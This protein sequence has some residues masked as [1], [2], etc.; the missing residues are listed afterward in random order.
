MLI[1]N[2]FHCGGRAVLKWQVSKAEF[3]LD[4]LRVNITIFFFFLRELHLCED[5]SFAN[6]IDV[7]YIETMVIWFAAESTV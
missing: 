5:I 7:A 3:R 4:E 2:K 6:V 1:S